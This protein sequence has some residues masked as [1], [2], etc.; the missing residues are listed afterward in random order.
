VFEI[1]VVR[2]I[3]GPKTKEVT[4]RWFDLHNEEI[5]DLNSSL[6]TIPAEKLRRRKA[7]GNHHTRKIR[8]SFILLKR[9]HLEDTDEDEKTA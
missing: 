4:G 5:H 3:S 1:K 9:D 6:H 8:N 2:I 7:W